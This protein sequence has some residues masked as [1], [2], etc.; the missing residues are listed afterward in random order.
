MGAGVTGVTPRGTSRLKGDG[1]GGQARQVSGLCLTKGWP[2]W[3]YGPAPLS[4]WQPTPLTSIGQMMETK[5]HFAPPGPLG[6]GGAPLGNMFD[7]VDD[8]TA[9]AALL[10]AWETN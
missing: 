7:V 4:N 9:E 3:V 5:L 10:A 6:L 8:Q 1:Q 2:L